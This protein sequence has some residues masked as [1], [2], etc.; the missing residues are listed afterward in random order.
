MGTSK[1]IDSSAAFLFEVPGSNLP[2]VV[3]ELQI[4]G[5]KEGRMTLSV[6]RPLTL[7]ISA[8]VLVGVATVAPV[9]AR[10]SHHQHIKKHRTTGNRGFDGRQ[11]ADRSWPGAAPSR[12]GD[13]CPGIGRSFECKIWPPPMNDDPDRKISGSDGS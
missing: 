3:Q 10:K 12:S 11:P 7:A 13:V 9:E 2:L 8:T 4:G 6:I 5:T 1:L